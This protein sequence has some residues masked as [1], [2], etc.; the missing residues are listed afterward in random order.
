MTV[1][2]QIIRLLTELVREHNTALIMITHDLALVSEIADKIIVMYCGKVV[3]NG[4]TE[5]I[6]VDQAHPY[7]RGLLNSIPRLTDEQT[8]LEQI[9]GMV[10]SPFQLPQ[11]CNFAPRC[12]YKQEICEQ[13]EPSACEISPGHTALCFFPVK[14][15]ETS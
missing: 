8:K 13:Q 1:Q 10:P 2:A 6:I 9:P 12:R 5:D 11:G 14:G 4:T 3:E 7:T 15:G